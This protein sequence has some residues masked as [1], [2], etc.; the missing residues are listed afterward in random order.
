[1]AAED[2]RVNIHIVKHEGQVVLTFSAEVVKI[3]F[4][5]DNAREIAQTMLALA[6]QIAPATAD[7]LST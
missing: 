1:M 3:G 7:S 4:L 5:P 6:D 2:E